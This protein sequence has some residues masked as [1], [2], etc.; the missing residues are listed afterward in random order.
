MSNLD[1][2]KAVREI[3]DPKTAFG[4]EKLLKLFELIVNPNKDG[5]FEVESDAKTIIRFEWNC[6]DCGRYH[7]DDVDVFDHG[8][9]VGR[10]CACGA[11][12]VIELFD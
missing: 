12:H 8:D 5:N 7:E 6:V 3:Y 1:V 4:N 2:M 10:K 9:K 11:K